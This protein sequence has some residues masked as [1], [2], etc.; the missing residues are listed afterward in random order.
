ME[1]KFDKYNRRVR[2]TG[3]QRPAEFDQ[4]MVGSGDAL[5]DIGK[6]IVYARDDDERGWTRRGFVAEG[7]IERFF[8]DGRDASVWSQFID[9]ERQRNVGAK[10]EDAIVELSREKAKRGATT[11]YPEG[12]S[13]RIAVE[14]DAAAISRLLGATFSDY[15]DPIDEATVTRWIENKDR[16]FRV[17]EREGVLV[18]CASA[19]VDHTNR[20]AELTD[21]ATSPEVRGKGIM[22][23]ILSDLEEYCRDDL[24]INDLYTLARAGEAGINIAFARLGY[25]YTGRLVNNC[26]MPDGWESMNAWCRRA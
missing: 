13:S 15:P 16:V 9:E 20:S 2:L 5:E 26:R 24:G 11:T 19:E 10:E 4:W 12:M 17:V 23:A 8:A 6:I 1:I 3:L 21:C 7:T 22:T 25:R 18:A 14:G